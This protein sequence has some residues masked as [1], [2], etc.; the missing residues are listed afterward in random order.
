MR[1]CTVC[2]HAERPAID[3]ALLA[4]EPERT[5]ANRW[6]ISRASVHRHRAHIG[7]RLAHQE[8]VTTARLLADLRDLQAKAQSL[9]ERAETE[10][11]LRGALAGVR[12]TR[13]VVL[14]VQKLIEAGDLTKRV[15][16]LERIVQ[17]RGMG[18]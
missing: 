2:S 18:K 3:R 12:E 16:E 11:D 7:A 13:E 5:I 14:A 4:G 9:L 10:G 17:E 15:A 6:G 8:E 1:V